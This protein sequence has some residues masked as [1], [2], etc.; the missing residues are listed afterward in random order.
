MDRRLTKTEWLELSGFSQLEVTYIVLGN[1]YAI[2]DI[3]KANNFKYSPLL[4]W[5]APTADFELPEG[6]S[7]Y[8]LKYSEFFTWDED[9]KTSFLLE[10]S[11]E[12]LETLFAP[13]LSKN[14]QWIGEIGE[15]FYDIQVV[16]KNISGYDTAYG[17]K[18]IYTFEDQNENVYTWFTNSHQS[19]AIDNVALL[20]GT[21][22][23]HVEYK[24]VRT[25]QLTRCRL[26]L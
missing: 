23:A 10:G 2:R 1:S 7:Y 5:H 19:I 24:G 15:R 17:Y 25:N 22:K 3:L 4:R 14:S 20:T 6:C 21:L 12:R 26:L 8:E 16:V 9:Q 18:Y 13:V 11:R